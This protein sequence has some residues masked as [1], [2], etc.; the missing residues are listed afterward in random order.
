MFRH[1]RSLTH[2]YFHIDLPEMRGPYVGLDGSA[3]GSDVH[4]AWPG[5]LEHYARC[6]QQYITQLNIRT[7]MMHS[8]LRI[9]GQLWGTSSE[10]YLKGC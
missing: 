1:C 9:E 8:A 5:A 7:D 2:T 6:L 4:A 10:L 3:G